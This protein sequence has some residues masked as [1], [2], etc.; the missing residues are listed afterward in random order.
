MKILVVGGSGFL[1]SHQVDS[2]MQQGH[3]VVVFDNLSTGNEKNL[4]QHVDNQ[5]FTFLHKDILKNKKLLFREIGKCDR[6]YHFAAHADVRSGQTDTSIDFEQNLVTTI[7]I[8]EGMRLSSKCKSLIFISSSSVYGEP[9]K[10]HIPTKEDYL[11]VQTSL[12]GASKLAGEQWVT[13]YSNYYGFKYWILRL[14]SQMGPRY[15]HGCIVDFLNKLKASNYKSIE[16][17]GNGRQKKSYLHVSDLISAINH[18]TKDKCGIYNVGNDK[19]MTVGEVLTWVLDELYDLGAPIDMQDF[20][21]TYAGGKRGWL[22]DSPNVLLDTYKLECLGWIP[23]ISQEK[24]I[25]ETTRWVYEH[26]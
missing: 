9:D 13:S 21:I 15:S 5:K 8:L 26:G 11:G 20:K 18:A 10:E 17:L 22:G 3:E 19:T 12:Y 25:K 16:I 1:G 4:T 24:A 2:L 23:L 14:V 6:V 7:C